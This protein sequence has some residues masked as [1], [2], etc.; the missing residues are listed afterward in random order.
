MGEVKT[1]A[2][3]MTIGLYLMAL[4]GFLC[5]HALGA[6]KWRMLVS[7]ASRGGERLIRP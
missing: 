1:A 4:A 6:G 3:Q 5:G 7:A 2:S